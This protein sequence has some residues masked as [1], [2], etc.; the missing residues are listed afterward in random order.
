MS[1]SASRDP[2]ARAGSAL[3]WRGAQLVAV[4]GLSILRLLILARL[5]VPEQFGLLSIA[6]VVVGTVSTVT[7]LGLV[8][9]LVQRAEVTP[10]HEAAAWTAGLLRGALLAALLVASAGWLAA[11]FGEPRA[12]PVLRLVAL[13]P[14]LASAVSLGLVRCRRELRFREP[15]LAAG[16][17]AVAETAVAV[18]LAS[19]WGVWALVAGILAGGAVEVALSY[20]LAPWRPRL[21]LDAGAVR[22]LLRYGRWVFATGVVAAAGGFVL[23]AVISRR[24]GAEALGLYYLAMKLAFLPSE[25]ASEVAGSVAFPLFARL[26]GD[27]AAVRRAF[28]ALVKGL[29]AALLPVYALLAATAPALPALLGEEWQGAAPV[30]RILAVAGAVGLFG[31]AA[32]PLLQGLGRPQG[33]TALE[34]VQSAVLALSVFGLAAAWGVTGAAGAWLPAVAASQLLAVY[35]VAG[36]LPRAFTGWGKTVAAALLAATATGVA[37]W[38]VLQALSGIPGL[39]TALVAG[40]VTAVALLTLADRTFRL[41]LAAELAWLVP[42]FGRRPVA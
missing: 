28:G 35:L 8:P 41:G 5:L 4:R 19:S 18:A 17:A 39:A 27:A 26:Q 9:A 16:G 12:A 31:D 14:L 40:A 29:A 30:L 1:G 10:R 33:V 24:L 22:P 11:L 37:A 20:L 3:A 2:A 36:V 15:A 34:V 21:R 23:Q 6:V 42:V 32:V 7:E 38:A 25:V 13:R